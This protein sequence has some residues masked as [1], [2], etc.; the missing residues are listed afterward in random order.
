MSRDV[1][2]SL[3][4]KGSNGEQILQILDSIADGV[5]DSVDP[6]SAANPTLS[7][8]QFWYLTNRQTGTGGTGKRPPRD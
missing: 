3:L 8:I 7:E 4:A 2:L 1:L 6:D 5:S